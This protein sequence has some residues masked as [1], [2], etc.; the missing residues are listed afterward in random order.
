MMNE[1]DIRENLIAM[2]AFLTSISNRIDR[3]LSTAS[4][5]ID[6]GK[7]KAASAVSAFAAA[8]PGFRD[9]G[10]SLT[11]MAAPAESIDTYEIAITEDETLDL[12]SAIRMDSS[13][14]ADPTDSTAPTNFVRIARKMWE[15][16]K[17]FP[18]IEGGEF[19]LCFPPLRAA[20]LRYVVVTKAKPAPLPR[21]T[22]L[23]T[24]AQSLL[25]AIKRN[26]TQSRHYLKIEGATC[27][28]GG[29]KFQRL[30]QAFWSNG[31]GG[32]VSGG[33][34]FALQ[35]QGTR[36]FTMK[37]GD[38]ENKHFPYLTLIRSSEIRKQ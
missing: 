29:P 4:N 5:H 30:A 13:R 28:T 37:S 15:S 1:K 38:Q 18:Y 20:T 24:E 27:C 32:P 19:M 26:D 8:S 23:K 34:A 17:L 11:A 2:R 6:A 12:K 9:F 33:E 7:E 3:L 16:K 14:Y 36:P 22:V 31:D 21:V 35:W 25:C 10:D